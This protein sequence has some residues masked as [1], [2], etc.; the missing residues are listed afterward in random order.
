MNNQFKELIEL[1]ALDRA[2]RPMQQVARS[3]AV[4]D[5][6]IVK[7][8][9]GVKK[10]SKA[11]SQHSA[12]IGQL[13]GAFTSLV[14]AKQMLGGIVGVLKPAMAMQMSMTRLKMLTGAGTEA[15]ADM[16]AEAERVAAATTYSPQQ[17][18]EAMVSLRRATGSTSEAM[19]LLGTTAN[20]AMASMGKLEPGKAADIIATTYRSF[21]MDVDEAKLSADKMIS[22]SM[23]MGIGVEELANTMGR[24]SVA[25][26]RGN[27]SFDEILMNFMLVQR[28][29]RSSR[30]SATLLSSAFGTLD[31]KKAQDALQGIAEVVDSSTGQI[32]P[33]SKIMQDIAAVSNDSMS[34]V[35]SAI[36]EA[37]GDQGVQVVLP[38]LRQL[39]Q[40]ILDDNA[41]VLKGA[42]AYKYFQGVL[43][44][45]PGALQAVSESYLGTMSAILQQVSEAWTLFK[46]NIGEALLPALTA[47]GTGLM[48]FTKILTGFFTAPGVKYVSAFALNILAVAASVKIL[49][50]ALSGVAAIWA[51]VNRQIKTSTVMQ[52]A[53]GATGASG[54]L[55]SPF[56][57]QIG[58]WFAGKKSSYMER[59][60][61]RKQLRSYPTMNTDYGALRDKAA[62]I[63]PV[64]DAFR[65]GVA[66]AGPFL[67]SILTGLVYESWTRALDKMEIEGDLDYLAN[68]F[69]DSMLNSPVWKTLGEVFGLA[70]AS[71]QADAQ[72]FAVRKMREYAE[73]QDKRKRAAD[74]LAAKEAAKALAFGTKPFVEAMAVLTKRFSS[75]E[76]RKVIDLGLISTLE[77]ELGLVSQAAAGGKG[78]RGGAKLNAGDLQRASAGFTGTG[79][80]I[81]LMR[82]GKA[83]GRVTGN[84]VVTATAGLFRAM[85]AISAANP[86]ASQGIMK[87]FMG[88]VV[89][90][91]L[92][93]LDPEMRALAM[94]TIRQGRGVSM[95]SGKAIPGYF[96]AVGGFPTDAAGAWDQFKQLTPGVP[97]EA[98]GSAGLPGYFREGA[99]E[100]GFK[101]P[102]EHAL[103]TAGS[104]AREQNRKDQQH[105]ADMDKNIADI[106]KVLKDA[107]RRATQSD[108]LY[109]QRP[110]PWPE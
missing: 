109:G 83:T 76:K 101:V 57:N 23:A 25:A 13:A 87:R 20:L 30:R 2:S 16:R 91:F 10:S 70:A 4:A 98:G 55:L 103:Q 97:Y 92:N 56:T 63:K 71:K 12:S 7:L 75:L 51:G 8:T 90:P 42:D 93:S 44:K 66:T 110:V 68:S 9:G 65:D 84:Q 107:V 11:A 27:Q 32:R 50:L 6:A 85:N 89:E 45:Q 73:A 38:I 37:F 24:L 43:A 48:G 67:L 35:R 29:L 33:F 106:A 59:R 102:A 19:S 40:G 100:H 79:A 52:A 54:G 82:T 5:T 88:G 36:N 94:D 77:K 69:L 81:D 60:A 58:S 64:S 47:I 86:E 34:N 31:T 95:Q 39:K 15:L 72:M 99:R 41:A 21:S 80:F 61:T 104:A 1:V 14:V 18:I 62:A 108:P 96:P 26:T 46:T 49:K 22:S 28:V 3:A 105:I 78:Y 17:M 53:A 74:L